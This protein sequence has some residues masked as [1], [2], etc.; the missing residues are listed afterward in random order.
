MKAKY[1]RRF[2][3]KS[4]RFREEENIGKVGGELE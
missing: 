3:K 4:G 2:R 1:R